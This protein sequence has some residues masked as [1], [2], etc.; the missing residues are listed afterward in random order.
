MVLAGHYPLGCS[1]QSRSG[2]SVPPQQFRRPMHG[3]YAHAGSGSYGPKHP[4]QMQRVS[5]AQQSSL[6]GGGGGGGSQH[7]GVGRKGGGLGQ[8][9]STSPAP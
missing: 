8:L 7:V 6:R 5:P 4:P 1:A 2:G 9:G 3:V